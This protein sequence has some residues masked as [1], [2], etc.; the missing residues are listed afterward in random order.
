MANQEQQIL[1]ERMHFTPMQIDAAYINSLVELVNA[2]RAQ[3]VELDKVCTFQ[4]GWHVTFKGHEG[5]DAVCHNHSY[6]SPR[7]GAFFDKDM[8]END[9]SRSGAWE[10]IGFPWDGD[11]V[12]VHDADEL[13][14]Y[15][16]CLD[17][18]LAPWGESEE[19]DE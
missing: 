10:T 11:D 12:S 13:A 15:L 17:N 3:H 9:W 2:C 14:F 5:A 19:E 8:P 4:G 6:G 7:Y 18:G 1:K 16:R